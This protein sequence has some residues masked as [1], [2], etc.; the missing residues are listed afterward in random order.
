LKDYFNGVKPAGSR[1]FITNAANQGALVYGLVKFFGDALGCTDNS[2]DAYGSGARPDMKAIHVGMGIQQSEFDLFNTVVIGELT[3]VGGRGK[4]LSDEVATAIH[5]FLN[6]TAPD[7][8][9]GCGEFEAP[10]LCEK[11][12]NGKQQKKRVYDV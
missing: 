6:A 8:C 11:W 2:I 3:S 1:D 4:G 5:V 10:S 9:A 7:V 12:H